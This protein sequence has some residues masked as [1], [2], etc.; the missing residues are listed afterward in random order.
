MKKTLL[1]LI[2]TLISCS[3][4]K[5][6]TVE[7]PLTSNS[8]EAVKLFSEEVF[9][10]KEAYRT[11]NPVIDAALK[12]CVELDPDFSLAQALIGSVGYRM[13]SEEA[14]EKIMIAFN[15]IENVTEIEAALI[16]SIYENIINGNVSKGESIL[17]DIVNKYPDYYYLKIY[18][19]EY[20][21]LVAQNP[22]KSERSWEE[23]LKIDPNNSLAKLLLSQLHYTSTS[24]IQLLSRDEIDMEKAINLIKEIE[25]AEPNNFICPRLL[26]N[27]YRRQ[28][29][30]DRSIKAY[31]KAMQ[32]IDD[33]TSMNYSQLLLVNGHNYVFKEEYNT[34]REL[35]AKAI[36]TNPGSNQSIVVF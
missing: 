31:E 35:Y 8:E 14:R 10:P 34:A 28:G 27:V 9:R 21:N 30:F 3:E 18:L 19:G 20:Q 2:L 32:I 17:E 1:I 22:K 25:K 12:K 29:D 15:N 36:E 16:N 7:I 13:K 5:I 26:G 33:E 6:D 24:D 23:A 11:Y 4:N